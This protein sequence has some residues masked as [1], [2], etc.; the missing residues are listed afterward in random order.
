[1]VLGEIHQVLVAKF[2][3]AGTT[4][5]IAVLAKS[6]ITEPE[7]APSAAHLARQIFRG[8]QRIAGRRVFMLGFHR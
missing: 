6:P 1:M 2:R 7:C 3:A 4:F 8:G 5:G